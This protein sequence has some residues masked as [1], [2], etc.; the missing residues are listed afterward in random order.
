MLVRRLTSHILGFTS[1]RLLHTTSRLN[2]D[3]QRDKRMGHKPKIDTLE[4]EASNVPIL[5]NMAKPYQLV[6]ETLMEKLID[7]IKFKDIPIIFI[8]CTRNNTKVAL[9]QG[10]GTTLALKSAGTEGYKNCR[11]GTTVCAQ[12]VAN[13]VVSIARDLN[14]NMARLVFD[15]LGPGRGAAYKVFELSGIKIVSLSDRT[16]AI[17]P[18]IRRPRKAKRL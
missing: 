17:E 16:E 6:D 7:N 3:D 12:A 18:W 1:S 15:G 10:D 5:T 11:K 2:G 8:I 14:V 13:R 4:G 9:T